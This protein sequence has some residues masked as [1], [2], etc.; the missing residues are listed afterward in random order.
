[1]QAYRLLAT[2][3]MR[4]YHSNEYDDDDDAG[5]GS[6]RHAN[7]NNKMWNTLCTY[8]IVIVCWLLILL[9]QC[10]VIVVENLSKRILN[11]IFVFIPLK[12]GEQRDRKRAGERAVVKTFGRIMHQECAWIS[13]ISE[14]SVHSSFVRSLAV[15]VTDKITIGTIFIV[16]VAPRGDSLGF[17]SRHFKC[18]FL[19]YRVAVLKFPS[20]ER[21]VEKTF[22]QILCQLKTQ[23]DPLNSILWKL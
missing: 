4:E 17:S 5:G 11:H 12:C 13:S 3:K 7:N 1:M 6:H 15:V 18:S 2:H 10:Y 14:Q 9:C 8:Y 20:S 21:L 23:T 19:F 16:H 22:G